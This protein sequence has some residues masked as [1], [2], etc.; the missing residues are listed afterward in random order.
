MRR[1]RRPLWGLGGFAP[2]LWR[3]VS[4]A[5]L[6]CESSWQV[7]SSLL[8]FDCVKILGF[9]GRKNL[10]FLIEEFVFSVVALLARHMLVRLVAD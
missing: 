9:F 10:K 1:P 6:E 4:L 3:G 7:P 5:V 8:V 2:R